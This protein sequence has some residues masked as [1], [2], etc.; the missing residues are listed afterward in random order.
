MDALLLFLLLVR[1][2][3]NFKILLILSLAQT[4]WVVVYTICDS[5][6]FNFVT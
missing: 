1:I 6:S 2:V 5:N 3:S 4:V